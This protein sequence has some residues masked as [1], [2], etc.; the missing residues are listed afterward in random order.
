MKILFR[1]AFFLALPVSSFAQT[2]H[3]VNNGVQIKIKPVTVVKAENFSLMNTSA[4]TD[5]GG[6]MQLRGNLV[7]EGAFYGQNGSLLSFTGTGLQTVTG[8]IPP[9]LSEMEIDN[10]GGTVLGLSVYV[11]NSLHL[12]DGHLFAESAPVYFTPTATNPDETGGNHI[13]GTAIMEARPVGAGFFPT[14][15][16]CEIAAG[17]DIGNLT[18]TRVTGTTGIVSSGGFSGIASKWTLATDFDAIRDVTFSWLPDWDNGKDLTNLHRWR[19]DG[20][21]WSAVSP[22][23]DISARIHTESI[24]NLNNTWTYSDADNPLDANIC[25]ANQIVFA[26]PGKCGY[27]HSGTSWDMS[28]IPTGATITW[29]MSGATG[30]TG[31]GSLHNT[32]FNVG[33]TNVTWTAILGGF[34]LNSCTFSVTV[35][36]SASVTAV[37]L[38]AEIIA[39]DSLLVPVKLSGILNMSSSYSHLR[40]RYGTSA[41]FLN[42]IVAVSDSAVA[43]YFSK[44]VYLQPNT[45]YY[46]ALEA[47]NTCNG[48]LT[49]GN[50][51]SFRTPINI[52]ANNIGADLR[53]CAG[54]LTPAI[55]S[56]LPANVNIQWQISYDSIH[57]ANIQNANEVQL[58]P[59]S[60]QDT[61]FYRRAVFSESCANISNVIKIFPLRR[62]I[63]SA[64]SLVLVDLYNGTNGANWTFPWDL[65]SPVLT[66]HG[67]EICNGK[68][69][70]IN[71]NN[72]NLTGTIPTNVALLGNFPSDYGNN[73]LQFDSFEP[74]AFL[75]TNLTA[76][77]Q[78]FI[79]E[80]IDTTVVEGTRLKLKTFARGNY[81]RYQWQKDDMTLAEATDSTFVIEAVRLSDAGK[82]SAF[83]SNTLI[84]QLVLH[85]RDIFVNV[86]PAAVPVCDSLLLVKLYNYTDG[87]NWSKKWDLYAPVHTWHGLSFNRE[88]LI[89]R[90]N[91]SRNNLRGALSD[92]FDENCSE[93]RRSL[94]FM[95]LSNNALSDVQG[96]LSNLS[97]LEYLDLSKN[98][99]K[100][101]IPHQIGGLASLRVLDFSGNRFTLCPAEIFNLP[102]LRSLRLADNLLTEI[103]PALGNLRELR[104]LDLSRN[105]LRNLP[106]SAGNLREAETLLLGSNEITSLPSEISLLTKMRVLEINNNRLQNLPNLRTMT[107]LSRLNVASNALEFDDLLPYRNFVLGDF[108]YAPQDEINE[109]QEIYARLRENVTLSVIT[110]GV[111]NVYQWSKDGKTVNEYASTL[112]ISSMTRRDRGIYYATIR[113]PEL[114]DLTLI[115]R[116]I[117]LRIN[118]EELYKPEIATDDALT[119]CDGKPAFVRF[120]IK[121]PLHV[122]AFRWYRNGILQDLNFSPS[123]TATD[124]G[125]YWLQATYRDGCTVKSNEMRIRPNDTELRIFADG[126]KLFYE[127]NNKVSAFQWFVDG[128]H[129]ASS[130]AEG[131]T[132]YA[133]K[134]GIYRLRVIDEYGCTIFSN[135]VKVSVTG[136]EDITNGFMVYPNPAK[137]VLFVNLEQSQTG[138]LTVKDALGREILREK[139]S[140]NQQKINIAFLPLG[141][142]FLVLKTENGREA[143]VKFIKD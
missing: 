127:S 75:G 139:I 95:D 109:K 44:V 10:G 11:R 78:E 30:G 108:S 18:L 83:V 71:L 51:V 17:S 84:T 54:D 92:V 133:F 103:S 77:P 50:I 112:Y 68:V 100:D 90:I 58:A 41:S 31:T 96:T 79:N 7:A 126:Y 70:R 105:R 13:V 102:V 34:P 129:Y 20:A 115:R 97:N 110:G 66:W 21:S 74:L 4:V 28:P 38:P 42:N 113:N 55:G 57:W 122:V 14:F 47:V 120:Y 52:A 33:L 91:L 64:D 69:V 36:S 82:Y 142:Y 26:D 24:N 124:T 56:A 65:Y 141:T 40:F 3:A 5:L 37:T 45:Q 39:C 46:Y 81:N 88:G 12:N 123:F 29:S 23:T 8:S 60:P 121:N 86:L 61:A 6:T 93:M 140:G 9:S 104:Q 76:A 32:F 85:R 94:R 1:L 67:V 114:P 16:N 132:L 15:L 101:T 62:F 72:N 59:F 111:G 116:I 130:F 118:C 138:I 27:R 43:G 19:S 117:D 137:G 2:L 125:T 87:P 49:H 136:T 25:P 107:A 134:A 89:E 48:F 99:F 106:T 35:Q 135:E 63:H 143:M 131:D 119:L 22:P 53:V 80:R 98:L 73:A 128:V